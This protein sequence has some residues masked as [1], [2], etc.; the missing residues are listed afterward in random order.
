MNAPAIISSALKVLAV[1]EALKGHTLTGLSNTELA[2]ATGQSAP[3]VS[4]ALATLVEGG[5]VT[6][7]E[8]GRYAHSVKTLQIAQAHLTHMQQFRT[9]AAELDQRISAGAN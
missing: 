5:Y 9:R 3:N 8:S 7:Y 6:R 1:W 4:R 2:A